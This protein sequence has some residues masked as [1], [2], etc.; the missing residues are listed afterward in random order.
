MYVD[1]L[2]WFG[3]LLVY[4]KKKTLQS[5][6]SKMKTNEFDS[7][8]SKREVPKDVRNSKVRKQDKFRR[9]WSRH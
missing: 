6:E 1:I 2:I 7:Q 8:L 5:S 9:D 4:L 3:N